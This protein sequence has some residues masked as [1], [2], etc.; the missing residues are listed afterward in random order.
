MA[1]QRPNIILIITDQQRFDTIGALG[2]DY[3]DT[4]HL[5]RLVNEGITFNQC[6]I[7]A[8]SCAPARAAL[9]TGRYPHTTRIF[10]MAILGKLLDC[11]PAIGR[12][13]HCQHRQNAHHSLLGARRF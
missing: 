13:P 5:D 11:R 4:P 3:M 10:K 9:F 1:D 7:P 8:T 6:H 2:F 12:L